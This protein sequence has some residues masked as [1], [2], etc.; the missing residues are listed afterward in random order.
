MECFDL[1]NEH[2]ARHISKEF[3]HLLLNT[4]LGE[5]DLEQE[6]HIALLAA[7]DDNRD[8]YVRDHITAVIAKHTRHETCYGLDHEVRPD[9]VETLLHLELKE[10]IDLIFQVLVER[11]PSIERTV[12]KLRHGLLGGRKYRHDEI[13]KMFRISENSVKRIEKDALLCIK[14]SNGIGH[15]WSKFFCA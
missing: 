1:E 15:I 8:Q 4:F 2:L 12:L 13:G 7:P 6:A 11:C 9:P 3:S 14:G 10:K 5:E